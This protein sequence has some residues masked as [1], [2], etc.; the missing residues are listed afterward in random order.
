MEMHTASS[1]QTVKS[2]CELFGNTKQAYYQRLSYTYK[3][4]V[5]GEVLY[6]TV[7]KYRQKMPRIGGRK[8][9]YLVNKELPKEIHIGRDR[10]FNW[11]RGNNLLVKKRKTKIYTTNSH[12]WLHKYPNLIKDYTPSAP[13]QLWVSDITYLRTEEGVMYLFLVTDAFS[14]KIVGWKLADNLRAENAL[15][16]L[17]MAIKQK[18]NEYQLIHHSDRGIQY[19]SEKYVK[20]LRKHNISISMTQNGNPLDNAI[21]ERINGILKDE[22]LYQITF[23]TKRSS[24][25]QMFK[26]VK[27]YN[28]LRPHLS[29][30]MQTPEQVHKNNIPEDMPK[31]FWKNYYRTKE[32]LSENREVV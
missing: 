16:A 32:Y 30:G 23:K 2:L 27:L 20:L 6:Q 14:K 12:H 13:D 25:V 21:A 11:L 4:E 18:N 5:K 3:T 28:N 8:L 24:E 22:W 1:K 7:V 19:C 31:R 26:I 10:F 17:R 15:I 9:H 29:L